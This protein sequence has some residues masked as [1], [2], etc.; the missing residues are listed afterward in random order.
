MLACAPFLSAQAPP[1]PSAAYDKRDF[2]GIWMRLPVGEGEI[3]QRFS[4]QDP[5]PLQPWAMEKY[6]A[7]REGTKGPN[8]DGRH[9]LDPLSYCFPAG[10]PRVML[11]NLDTPMEVLQQSQRL[12]ILFERNPEAHRVY[13]DGRE[14]PEGLPPTFMGYSVGRWEGDILVVEATGLNDKTWLDGVGTPH[15]DALRVVERFR[16]VDENTLEIEFLFDDSKAFTK[17]WG[18]KKI[19]KLRPDAE[20]FEYV[21]CEELF[22]IGKYPGGG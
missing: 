19:Y 7:H 20:I 15:S 13:T 22:Q 2:S 4:T 11:L 5:P 9:E 8:D 12:H 3:G 10:L 17:P 21:P 18:G 6:T 1:K 14:L 16:R